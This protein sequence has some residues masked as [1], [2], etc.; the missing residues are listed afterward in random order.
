LSLKMRSQP[1]CLKRPKLQI[2]PKR[3]CWDHLTIH[4][5]WSRTGDLRV[6]DNQIRVPTESLGS[7]MHFFYQAVTVLQV[8]LSLAVCGWL[9]QRALSR[10][11]EVILYFVAIWGLGQLIWLVVYQPKADVLLQ[12]GEAEVAARDAEDAVRKYFYETG[13]P[14]MNRGEAGLPSDPVYPKHPHG[15]VVDVIQGTVVVTFSERAA[16]PLAGK[17]LT[18]T[19]YELNRR[20]HWSEQSPHTMPPYWYDRRQKYEVYWRCGNAGIHES[21]ALLGTAAGGPTAVRLNTTVADEH[22]PI[23]CRTPSDRSR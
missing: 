11:S 9:A 22:L 19:P 4:L 21:Y 12:V 7:R 16:G 2:S 20:S 3:R 18:M 17:S 10:P 14:P 23:N 13:V 8:L 5:Q 6:S 15:L 1:R